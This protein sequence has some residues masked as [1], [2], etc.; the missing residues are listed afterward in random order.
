ML[1]APAHSPFDLRATQVFFNERNRVVQVLV[2]LRAAFRNQ[3]FDLF[4]DVR[5][6][7]LEGQLFKF[8][9][10]RV[11]SQPVSQGSVNL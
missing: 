9:L 7:R 3:L 11:H 5:V 4:K 10:D 2:S 6:K 8:P 1:W